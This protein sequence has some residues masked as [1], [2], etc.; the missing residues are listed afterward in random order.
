MFLFWTFAGLLA[1]VAAA[2]L[3]Y[4]L[5]AR[6]GNAGV[7][8]DALNT[9]LY[10]EQLAELDADLRSG[11]IM[12]RDF[13]A[14]RRELKARL[15]EDVGVA[16]SRESTRQ[17]RGTAIAVGLAVPAC[18]IGIYLL[19]GS[20]QLLGPPPQADRAAEL[21]PH[22]IEAMVERLAERLKTDSQNVE[23]WM[24]LA[25]SYAAFGRFK[26]SAD[27][28]ATAVKLRPGD[29]QLL[30]DYAD[31][32]GMSLGR[33]L[34]GEPEKLVLRALEID[35]RNLKALALAGSAAF[36]RKEYKGAAGYWERMLPLVPA[37]SDDARS[38]RANVDEARALEKGAPPPAQAAAATKAGLR[39]E[40]KLAPAL[41]AN[42]A[43]TDTV[44]IFARAVQ[45]PPMPLAVL[46][47]QVRDLPVE[48]ALDD[49]MAMA[50]GASLSGSPQVIVGARISKS[51]TP[52]PQP[53]DLQGLSA[54]VANDASGVTIVIDSVVR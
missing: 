42:A 7:S 46:R 5:L 19:V 8:S 6:R 15:V 14:A 3:L 40:V 31:A 32:L 33:K 27:A 17:S 37:D 25:R 28:Y 44:F 51:G 4:P 26:E 9:A 23:G 54:P 34:G 48:F 30:A 2:L 36:E 12:Q 52:T 18:A 45:G 20:P 50:P 1:A 35:P 29:A 47:K 24:L 21:T 49:S 22:E 13:D 10:A 43:P 53:G 41:A 39:G 11:A 16:P 38:I